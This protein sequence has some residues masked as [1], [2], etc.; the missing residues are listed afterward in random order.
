M[1]ESTMGLSP[2][3]AVERLLD[4]EHGRVLR[5]L[6]HE[7]LHRGGE[8]VV[9]VV[10]Q[11]VALAQHGEELGRLVGR[12]GQADRRH[13]ASSS[14]RAGRAG[15]GRRRPTART[16]RA[17][18]PRGRRRRRPPRARWPSSSRCTSSHVGADLE[19][20]G[21]AEAAAAQLHLDGHQQVVGLVLFE[22]Q[23]GVAGDPEGMVLPDRHAGEQGVEVGGDD[24]LERHEA[25]AVGHDHE[26]GQHRRHLDP[27]DAAARRSSGP[28]PRPPG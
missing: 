24:L 16:G 21:P 10:H 1:S 7:G 3:G 25:L 13:R 20:Q 8:G 6:G 4:P 14:R 2:A 27:G 19:A 15:P 17:G 12:R 23:V 22:G 28:A 26:A 5:G 11:D 9:G 18:P